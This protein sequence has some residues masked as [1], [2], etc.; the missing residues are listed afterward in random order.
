MKVIPNER[1]ERTDCCGIIYVV[2]CAGF[3]QK[4][5]KKMNNQKNIK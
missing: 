5:K 4:I 1:G 3:N 2:N